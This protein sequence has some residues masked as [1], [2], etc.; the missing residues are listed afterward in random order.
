[1]ITCDNLLTATGTCEGIIDSDDVAALSLEI[2]K[3]LNYCKKCNLLVESVK[4]KE[5]LV[6]PQVV[7]DI[8]DSGR[9]NEAHFGLTVRNVKVYNRNCVECCSSDK[10]ADRK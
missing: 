7:F 5:T 3:S 8:Y 9:E 6:Y 1:M 10:L 4:R 2:E